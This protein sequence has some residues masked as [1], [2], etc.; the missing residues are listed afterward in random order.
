MY[1]PEMNCG[2][3]SQYCNF[4]GDE[5]ECMFRNVTVCADDICNEWDEEV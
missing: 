3:C 5:G 4:N 2:N 1:L